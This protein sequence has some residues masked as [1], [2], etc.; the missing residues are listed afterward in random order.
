M[1]IGQHNWS[2][3]DEKR[4]LAGIGTNSRTPVKPISKGVRLRIYL[5][6]MEKRVEWGHINPMEVRNF[7]LS[8][9]GGSIK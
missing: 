5:K 9:L 2:T 4:W 6:N 7:I 3:E 8:L 1:G